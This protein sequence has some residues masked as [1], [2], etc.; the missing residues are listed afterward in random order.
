MKLY[1]SLGS[2]WTGTQAD[3]KAAQ[4]GKDFEEIDVPTDK[5]GLMAWLN[6]FEVRKPGPGAPAPVVTETDQNEA[7]TPVVL[8]TVGNPAP[9]SSADCP[10]CLRSKAVAKMVANADVALSIKAD[11]SAVTDARSLRAIIKAANDRIAELD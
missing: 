5:P 1:R 3:A 7:D 4:N 2:V 11:I 6:T 8:S 9:T 10:A